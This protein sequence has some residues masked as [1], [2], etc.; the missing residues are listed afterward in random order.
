[1]SKNFMTAREEARAALATQE[2]LL[3]ER[4]ADLAYYREALRT[5]KNA[6]SG[7]EDEPE[8]VGNVMDE[9][10]LRYTIRVESLEKSVNSIRV[11]IA[12]I[13]RS[14][15]NELSLKPAIR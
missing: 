5:F 13:R 15:N 1:M 9:L 4:E 12:D 6:Q 2:A 8:E 14:L 11:N 7:L 3:A 10:V